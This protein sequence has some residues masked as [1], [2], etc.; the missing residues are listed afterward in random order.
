M[1]QTS[2]QSKASLILLFTFLISVPFQNCSQ[3]KF[4][5]MEAASRA[6]EA[7]R[8]ALGVAEEL[9]TVGL[10]PVP[11]L[12]LFFIVDN[13]G[14][15]KQNQLNLSASFGSMFDSS[16]ASLSKFDSTTYLLNTA[17]SVPSFT[18]EKA[19]L[20]KISTQQGSYS[21]SV[22]IPEATFN[23]SV[24]SAMLNFGYFPGD[25]I[26]YQIKKVAAPLSYQMSA[27]PVLGVKN[28]GGQVSVS[29]S[30][31]KT[32]SVDVADTEQEFKDR[33][34]ILSSDRIPMVLAGAVYKP[35]N[36]TVVDNESG[37]CA[38]ARILKN[39]DQYYKAGDLLSFTIVSDENDN[40]ASGTKCI[41][42]IT[43]FNGTEDLVDGDCKFRESQVYFKTQST[44]QK[45]EDCKISA[46]AGYNYKFTYDTNT[47]STDVTYKYI[48]T[49]AAYKAYYYNLQ[50]TSVV[51]AYSYY[52]TDITYFVQICN[53]VYNDGNKTGVRCVV[54]PVAK[55]GAKDGD[56]VEATKCYDLA[57]SLNA[58][59][60]NDA[61]YKPVCTASFKAVTAACLAADPL[62]QITPTDKVITVP[63]SILGENKP[64]TCL[65]KAM[66]Y[67]DY[68]KLPVC[69]DASKNVGSCS[70]DEAASKCDLV[71]AIVYD[72]KSE[73]SEGDITA[74]GCLAFAKGRTDSAVV[75]VSDIT[76]CAKKSVPG[77]A[78]YTDKLTFAET[79]AL[80]GGTT[81]P[82]GETA[83]CGVL[84]SLAEGRASAAVQAVKKDD[85]VL[86]SIYKAQDVTELKTAMDCTIQ[87]NAKCSVAGATNRNCAGTLVSY[88]PVTTTNPTAIND[89]KVKEH[90]T[91]ASLCSASKLM[92]CGAAPPVGLTIDGHLKA[93]YG[94]AT[95]C[96]VTTTVLEA[97][98]ESL[99]AKLQS[100]ESMLCPVSLA[101]EPRYFYRTKGPYRSQ[102][103]V[104]E[105]VS[106]T[107]KDA[108]NQDQVVGLVEYIKFKVLQLSSSNQIVFSALVRKSTDPLGQGGTVGVDYKALIDQT[109]GQLDSVLS[110]DY[111]IALR[112]L[113]KVIKNNLERT[114]ILTK[115]RPDQIITKVS[116]VLKGTKTVVELD[117]SQWS[118]NLATLKIAEG[119][120]FI[121]GDQF[122]IDFQNVVPQK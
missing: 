9:V 122:K 107:K 98:K 78:E 103:L 72:F 117:P 77:T 118:Q 105:Y 62:C 82:V 59:A 54:D 109:Q 80:D 110:A 49:P 34:A 89:V 2:K 15:M 92:A 24:R 64:A 100:Q 99:V 67:A 45:P 113:S 43:Q 11:D 115:M 84:K 48:K 66:T 91:C 33:L 8:L 79:Q 52:N 111:S 32:A 47:I 120:E 112:E 31:R 104:T 7:E 71:S 119:L 22:L 73:S 101:G 29:N 58:N 6:L 63:G 76:V 90:L 46:N 70:T 75:A 102:A 28:T 57:K 74:D 53:D 41:Q 51:N 50:Y 108:N 23:A 97:N 94:T 4:M 85:C 96:G 86:T 5:D 38:V 10:N 61:G 1:L 21:P 27:A 16:S 93:K 30:I 19:V 17:Q 88:A 14:T 35:E 42:S 25:N 69:T 114:F 26:G 40:N 18:T 20:D 56:Y 87:A 36:A 81:L 95:V 83:S 37:L 13:S 68:N 55:K 121:E 3:I 44:T 65:A 60:I 12:K 116:L 39:P 106:G